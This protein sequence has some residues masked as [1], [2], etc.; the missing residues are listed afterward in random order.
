LFFHFLLLFKTFV[1]YKFFTPHN[2]HYVVEQHQNIKA[3]YDCTAL[4]KTNEKVK[5]FIG[6]LSMPFLI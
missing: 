4:N 1:F 2:S 3:Q 5:I 6:L